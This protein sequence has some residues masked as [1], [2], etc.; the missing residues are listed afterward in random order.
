[1]LGKEIAW[2]KRLPYLSEEESVH[3]Y[4]DIEPERWAY[5]ESVWAQ[6]NNSEK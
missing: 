6:E 2:R 1:M 4:L 5:R 3:N